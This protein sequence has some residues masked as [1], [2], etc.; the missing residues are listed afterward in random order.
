MAIKT[1]DNLDFYRSNFTQTVFGFTVLI[2][3]LCSYSLYNKL[4]RIEVNVFFYDLYMP[5]L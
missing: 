2:V 5:F 3:N 4:L 1:P